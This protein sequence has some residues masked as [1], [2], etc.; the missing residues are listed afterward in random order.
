M[1]Q[2]IIGKLA[3]FNYQFEVV[4]Y[5]QFGMDNALAVSRDYMI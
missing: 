2:S 1:V 4:L 5:D 3:I